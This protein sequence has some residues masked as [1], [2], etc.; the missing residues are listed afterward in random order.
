MLNNILSQSSST[1]ATLGNLNNHIGVPLSLLSLTDSHKYAVI[2]M[3][4]NHVGEI[5]Y[6]RKI[7]EPD[8]AIVTNTLDAHIGEFGGFEN[9]V[10]T[11]ERYTPINR[12]IFLTPQPVFLEIS[13]LVKMPI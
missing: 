7:A 13:V 10:K 3:G 9:L 12:P 5:D 4:A 1:F 2:E 6:L 8:V 11:K